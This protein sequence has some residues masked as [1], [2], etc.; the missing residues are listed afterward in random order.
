MPRENFQMNTFLFQT[1]KKLKEKGQR[2]IQNSQ[3]V[4]MAKSLGAAK[5][6]ECS[7]LTEEGLTNVFEEAVRVALGLSPKQKEGKKNCILY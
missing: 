3:G 4:A 5:Y 6:L 7:A 1:I 2:P